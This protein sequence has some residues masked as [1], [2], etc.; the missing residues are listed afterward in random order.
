M[1]LRQIALLLAVVVCMVTGQVLFKLTAR[2]LQNST[3]MFSAL[4]NPNA[5]FF[6]G[7]AALLYAGTSVLWIIAL[8][9]IDLSKAY[10]VSAL[11]YAIVPL[12]S[13]LLFAERVSAL[14]WLGILLIVAGVSLTVFE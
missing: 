5:L 11:S 14:G 8:R 2:A 3:G 13:I 9:S 12:L 4:S 10:P 7:S 6:G 1:S